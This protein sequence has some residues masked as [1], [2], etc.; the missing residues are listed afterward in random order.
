MPNN[1]RFYHMKTILTALLLAC[2]LSALAAECDVQ[3]R[4]TVT[5][6]RVQWGPTHCQLWMVEVSEDLVT[7]LPFDGP[8][9]EQCNVINGQQVNCMWHVLHTANRTQF[10]RLRLAPTI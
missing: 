5:L 2:G 8:R 1:S 7:W 4:L 3:P 9:N 10:Y 6:N